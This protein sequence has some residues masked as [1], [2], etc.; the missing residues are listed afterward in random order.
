[1]LIYV[2]F[3]SIIM[4]FSLPSLECN[5]I[6]LFAFP[7]SQ[8]L[9]LRFGFY[10]VFIVIILIVN[11]CRLLLL[12]YVILAECTPKAVW[13]ITDKPIHHVS[14][15]AAVHAGSTLILVDIIIAELSGISWRTRTFYYCTIAGSQ[16]SSP[17]E[18]GVRITV[19]DRKLAPVATV[20]L[21]ARARD[22]G[23]TGA[24]IFACVWQT[25]VDVITMFTC[26]M[27]KIWIS[28]QTT[29]ISNWHIP[30]S[31]ATM[32]VTQVNMGSCLRTLFV[33]ITY[34]FGI[35]IWYSFVLSTLPAHYVFFSVH[36]INMLL[37]L[38]RSIAS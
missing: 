35:R 29:K 1:M 10:M 20:V 8:F 33:M 3:T 27:Y 5:P 34:A 26:M 36:L 31:K 11:L 37:I 4:F 6:L 28:I 24:I 19:V 22:V 18:A 15:G 30:Q 9:L 25:F 38:V 16:T 23:V 21:L 17:V 2:N 32:K 14:A 7:Q 13:A 12:M